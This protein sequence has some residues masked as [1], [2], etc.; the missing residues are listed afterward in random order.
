M[1]IQLILYNLKLLIKF[2]NLR[3]Q[4][5]YNRGKYDIKEDEKAPEKEEKDGRKVD[6]N[7]Q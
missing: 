1:T 4:Y 7:L 3:C 5:S 2:K 6:R